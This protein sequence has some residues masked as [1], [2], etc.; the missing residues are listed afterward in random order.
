MRVTGCS[1]YVDCGSAFS[2]NYTLQTRGF[3][4]HPH[5]DDRRALSRIS[6]D[7]H[8]FIFWLAAPLA[9]AGAVLA[10]TRQ[11]ISLCQHQKLAP[12]RLPRPL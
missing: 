1:A 2:L 11:G 8:A 5:V 7:R 3:G 10:A 6:A 9:I 4:P 12:Q